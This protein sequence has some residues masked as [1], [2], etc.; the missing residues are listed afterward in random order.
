MESV[1]GKKPGKK[2]TMRLS[3][4]LDSGL[5]QSGEV[6]R[7][8]VSHLLTTVAVISLELG[9]SQMQTKDEKKK[10]MK[11]QYIDNQVYRV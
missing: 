8:K 10:K 11:S 7:Y 3:E 2:N 6:L 1:P 9:T 4:L 5:V